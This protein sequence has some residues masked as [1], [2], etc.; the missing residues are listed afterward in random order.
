MTWARGR[1]PVGKSLAGLRCDSSGVTDVRSDA[2]SDAALLVALEN[3]DRDALTVLY[4][5][6]AP[7][8]SRRLQYRCRDE[9]VVDAALHDTFVAVWRKPD[10]YKGKGDVGAWMWGIAIRRLIDQLRRAKHVPMPAVLEASVVA[11]E[12]EALVGIEHGD[13]AAAVESLAPELYAVVQAMFL[14]GLTSRETA[15]LLGLPQGT[16]KTRIARARSQLRVDL[17]GVVP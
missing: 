9:A 15:R 13:L 12:D 3:G 10:S 2:P 7:W 5:R 14:D 4:H 8:L 11:A 6:H 1:R 16:V 17:I